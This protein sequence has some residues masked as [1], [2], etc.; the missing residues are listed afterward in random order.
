MISNSPNLVSQRRM[1]NPLKRHIHQR[2][3]ESLLTPEFGKGRF[4]SR[5]YQKNSGRLYRSKGV[6]QQRVHLAM[7]KR[8]DRPRLKQK[9]KRPDQ[10]ISKG[11]KRS[12]GRILSGSFEYGLLRRI[13]TAKE[14]SGSKYYSMFRLFCVRDIFISFLS[15]FKCNRNLSPKDRVVVGY[16]W[17]S[18][19][20]KYVTRDFM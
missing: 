9:R 17:V 20:Y 12:S 13:W 19:D 7:N 8:N 15:M 14:E 4:S 1:C 2:K 16:V 10:M 18:L 5:K 11:Q 6:H 3:V